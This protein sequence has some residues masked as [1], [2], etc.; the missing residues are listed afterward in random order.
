M[1]HALP[2][3]ERLGELGR[4]KSGSGRGACRRETR[5]FLMPGVVLLGLLGPIEVHA[6][7]PPRGVVPLEPLAAIARRAGLRVLESQRLILA[8]DRPVRAGDGVDELPDVFDQAFATWCAHYRIDP[9]TLA[10]W[11]VFGCL[12]VEREVFRSAGLLPDDIPPFANGFCAGNRFWLIDQSNP[13][14]R[15]HLLLHE[16]V[17]AFTL[18]VRSLAAP[19]WYAEGIAEY[20]ATHRLERPPGGGSRL[21][22]TPIPE[23][24]GDVEQLGRIEQL[25]RLDDAEA[26]PSLAEVFAIRPGRHDD[27]VAYATSWAAVALLAG[28]PAH[29]EAF[30][31]LEQG[32]LD[33][34]LGLRLERTAGWD[35]AR[36][37][38]DFAAFTREVDY[39]YDFTR[40]AID[41]SAGERLVG[42]TTVAVDA[43]RGWQNTGLELSA[44]HRYRMVASGR[45][46]IGSLSHPTTGAVT[47][48]E[49]EAEGI[50][51]RWYRGRPIGRLLAAQWVEPVEPTEAGD[52]TSTPASGLPRF[53]VVAE[54]RGGEF[55]A[56]TTG[57]L[58]V[59]INEPP[60]ELSDN[61]GSLT[62]EITTP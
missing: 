23:R 34:G 48:L 14:Y 60:G 44:G 46:R 49:S 61:D 35:A 9:E 50:S 51:L 2:A 31:R 29:A 3:R 4:M 32:P 62:L 38:R 10:G 53:V 21:R 41:W 11:R 59:K 28:H 39:G 47:V 18:T 54:G 45:Y 6:V 15:R 12:M 16:G 19:V 8:T 55:I 58:F 43:A 40:S 1:P 26:L 7:D 52:R 20:L 24:A 22:A 17:H 27:L 42:R 30:A 25:R 57:P 56:P 33:Q 37:A 5:F 36:A 13:A